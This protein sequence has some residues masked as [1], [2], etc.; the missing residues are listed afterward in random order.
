MRKQKLLKALKLTCILYVGSYMVL[1]ITGYYHEIEDLHGRRYAVW[2]PRFC[3][4][5][6]TWRNLPSTDITWVGGFYLPLMLIDGK[7]IHPNKLTY[8]VQGDG[9]E[10]R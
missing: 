9:F 10:V 8:S 7:V 2:H 1:S 5:V 3:R 6:T 4:E